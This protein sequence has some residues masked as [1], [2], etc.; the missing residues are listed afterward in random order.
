M[1]FQPGLVFVLRVQPES[2]YLHV[3]NTVAYS[4]AE[5]RNYKA[6]RLDTNGSSVKLTLV[7]MRLNVR[8]CQE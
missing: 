5:K 6:L 2:T 1:N 8:A 7:N 3:T 4:N